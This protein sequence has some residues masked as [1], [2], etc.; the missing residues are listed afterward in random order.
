MRPQCCGRLMSHELHPAMKAFTS[1]CG[2]NTL[3]LLLKEPAN[4]DDARLHWI[5]P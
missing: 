5:I 4:F 2:D 3:A 1:T